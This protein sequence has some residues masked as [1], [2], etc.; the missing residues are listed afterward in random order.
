MSRR[1]GDV[2][3]MVKR[4]GFLSAGLVGTGC[5]AAERASAPNVALRPDPACVMREPCAVHSAALTPH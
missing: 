5:I 4:S 1:V 3:R 2:R